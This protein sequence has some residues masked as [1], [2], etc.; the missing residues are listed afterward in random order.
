[1]QR[2]ARLVVI[3]IALVAGLGA[4]FLASGSRPPPAPQ[5]VQQAPSEPQIKTIEVLTTTA[6]L[7]IGTVVQAVQL[8]WRK[9]PEEGASTFA[10]RRSDKPDAIN[11]FANSIVRIAMLQGEP[12]RPEKL[13]KAD[14]SGFMSAI[15]PSGMRALALPIDNRGTNSAGGF[16]LP[17]D[18]VDVIRTMRD[19]ARSKSNQGETFRADTLLTNIRVLAIGQN[20]QE[21]NGEKHVTGE[22]A[23]L[24]LT[25]QQVETV[26]HALRI[27]TLSLALRS[28]T[29]RNEVPQVVE[30][31]TKEGEINIV[32]FGVVSSR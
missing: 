15:L 25:P 7:P 8:E 31:L 28:I 27:G 5:V 12:V 14:G 29:D 26:L 30:G 10:I 22:N 4:A 1:M 6:E 16:I 2:T 13:I 21:R 24:E 20:V 9:W 17:N 23:T 32:R 18:R 3:G 19:E 11:E